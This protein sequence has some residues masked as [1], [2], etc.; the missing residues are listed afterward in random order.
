MVFFC[1]AFCSTDC[2]FSL[3]KLSQSWAVQFRSCRCVICHLCMLLWNLWQ[4]IEKAVKLKA[5]THLSGHIRISSWDCRKLEIGRMDLRPGLCTHTQ[6]PLLQYCEYGQLAV[7]LCTW[8]NWNPCIPKLFR[9]R[10]IIHILSISLSFAYFSY[11]LLFTHSQSRK[12]VRR[13]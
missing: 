11:W 6:F 7:C 4:S 5:V 1:W 8:W 12:H 9:F 2:T 10:Y 3:S 13:N